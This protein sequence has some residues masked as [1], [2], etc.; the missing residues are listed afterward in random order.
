M[1]CRREGPRGPGCEL[2][3]FALWS[4]TAERP[5]AEEPGIRQRP[6][7]VM[8]SLGAR[9]ELSPLAACSGLGCR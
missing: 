1:C 2:Q 5:A 4:E 9:R 7:A 3:V 6:A 8:G